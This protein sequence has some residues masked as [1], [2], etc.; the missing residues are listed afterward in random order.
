MNTSTA[1]HQRLFTNGKAWKRWGPYLSDRAWSS[2][3]EDNSPDGNAWSSFP[4]DHARSR[5]Y[6]WNEDGIGGFSDDRQFLCFAMA[7]WN[8]VDPILKE[9]FFGLDNSEGNHGEDVKEYY[10]YVDS[11]PTHSYMRM[12]YKYPQRAFPYDDLVLTNKGRSK[13][14]PEY[15][16]LD[17][18]AFRENRYFDAIIEYAK[19]GPDDLLARIEV[20]NRGPEEATLHLLPTLWFRN[21]WSWGHD[22][23]ETHDRPTLSASTAPDAAAAILAKHEI[24]G[25]YVL[26]CDRSAQG[27]PDLLF[28]ENETNKERLFG[29]ANSTLFVKD[30][31]GNFLIK[32]HRGAVNP[33]K[34]GTKASALYKLVVPAGKSAVVRLRLRSADA[35]GPAFQDFDRVV[36]QRRSEADEFYAAVQPKE[37]S[38]DLRMVQ[39]QAWAG[40]LWSKQFYNYNVATWLRQ[41]AEDGSPVQRFRRN[42]DWYHFEAADVI[43]MP[44]KWEYP[45]FAAWDLAFHSIALAYV[46][47]D[48]AKAQL[49]LLC[50]E[51]YQH[52]NGSLPAYE[53]NFNDVNP[54]VLAR[55][56][57]RV[58]FIDQQIRGKGDTGFLEYMFQK[59]GFTYTWWVNR[60]DASGNN[61]FEGGFLGLDNIGVF[62]RSAPLP[63]GGVL[64]QADG[65]SWMGVFT[66]DMLSIATELSHLNPVYGE[67]M[68]KYMTHF[69]YLND[70][71]NDLGGHGI[72][73]WDR[74]DGFFYDVLNLGGGNVIPLK[75]RSMVGLIPLFATLAYPRG[76]REHVPNFRP[77][78][79]E[80]IKVRPELTPL[81]REIDRTNPSGI[82]IFS[83]VD[84]EKLAL[85]LSRMLDEKEF[86]SDYGI[87][88]LSRYH[89]D[90]PYSFYGGS[91][92]AKV[93]YVPGDSDS[94]MFGGNSNWRGPIWFPVNYFLLTALK[95]FSMAFG[96]DF[97]VEFPA[98]SGALKTLNEVIDGIT[99]RLTSLFTR[100]AAGKRPVFGDVD[101]FNNDPYWRDLIPFYEYFHGDTGRGI[102]AAHQTGWTG[103]VAAIIQEQSEHAVP[104]G[105]LAAMAQERGPEPGQGVAERTKET[106]IRTAP[107]KVAR[108]SPS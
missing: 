84:R 17:T 80:F 14:E 86:L 65:T 54:P 27:S 77:W 23:Q 41:G 51:R 104:M 91:G 79:E 48:F 63:S 36:S 73:L 92:G 62:D 52:P 19:A 39:R 98:G 102:G 21:T 85:I 70:A 105:W 34:Q 31:I 90:Q 37:I 76:A 87:R 99:N 69:L 103:L 11:T 32:R 24:L 20:F 57:R 81:L 40:M 56:A 2:V 7:F 60:K 58:Y 6:R 97:K 71:F 5:A 9:R 108:K 88:S 59:L 3:R 38:D 12:V 82:Q 68:A 15:E 64:E 13:S 45:W 96:D 74:E 4:H 10:F 67:M 26:A 83:M 94:G 29:Q 25:S 75:V 89:L 43:S 46:D 95:R 72:S 93:S 106:V 42:S 66:L 28:T 1:E 50:S 44:D 47:P 18:G 30:G 16:L 8:G 61:L 49:K 78:L 33:L 55:A 101:L 35:A 53:W 107:P 22:R 100:N